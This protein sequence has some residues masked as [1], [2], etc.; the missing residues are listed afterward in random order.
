M[1]TYIFSKADV[2][3]NC[4]RRGQGRGGLVKNPG[5]EKTDSRIAIVHKTKKHTHVQNCVFS[6]SGWV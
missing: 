2:N 5:S 1:Y 3:R 6:G 4:I